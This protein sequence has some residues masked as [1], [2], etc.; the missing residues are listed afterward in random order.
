MKEPEFLAEIHKNQIK[1]YEERVETGVTLKEYMLAI[2]QETEEKRR[3]W[4][5]K[6]IPKKSL[7]ISH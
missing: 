6:K 3:S 1:A 4:G 2:E 5:I 7:S